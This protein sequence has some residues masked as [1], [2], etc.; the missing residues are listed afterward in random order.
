VQLRELLVRNIGKVMELPRMPPFKQCLCVLTS[1]RADHNPLSDVLRHTSRI[2][3]TA[4][5][6]QK[7]LPFVQS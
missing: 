2:R 3:A 1:E 6:C 7:D 5:S 4:R